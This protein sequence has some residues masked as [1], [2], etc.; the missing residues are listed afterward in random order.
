MDMQDVALE[1]DREALGEMPSKRKD[2]NDP[3]TAGIQQSKCAPE[4][5]ILNDI[6]KCLARL[7]D[8][9]SAEAGCHCATACCRIAFEGIQPVAG[10]HRQTNKG[11]R[12]GEYHYP[13][14]YS[15]APYHRN[16]AVEYLRG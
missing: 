6:E 5:D 7:P 3:S 4:E 13:Y 15:G 11:E 1:A 2:E 9:M 14:F 12:S 16:G 10:Y 8:S